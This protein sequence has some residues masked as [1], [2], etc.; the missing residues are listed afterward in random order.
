MHSNSLS[1]F[2]TGDEI[3]KVNDVCLKGKTHIA[4][5]EVF[6]KLKKGPVSI[7]FQPRIPT[8]RGRYD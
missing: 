3:I 1:Y 4:A 5:L 2:F 7:S 8:P 6:R